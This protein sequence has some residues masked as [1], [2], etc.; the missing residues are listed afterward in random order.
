MS[1]AAQK[2]MDVD[3]FLAW[4]EGRTRPGELR[5]GKPVM[6]SPERALH[7]LAEYE[8]QKALET[9]IA[10]ARLPCRLLPDGMTVRITARN[11]FEPDALVVCPSP[12]DFSAM[13][14]PN[15][16][17]VVEVLSL[18]T[19]ADD[20]GIRL[21]GYFSLPCVEHYLIVDADRPVLAQ[22]RASERAI[23]TRPARF[24][25]VADALLEAK[26][27][28]WR[29]Q[30]HREQWRIALAE[31]AAALRARNRA[32]PQ[33]VP[34]CETR[35]PPCRARCRRLRPAVLRRRRPTRSPLR[36]SSDAPSAWA[37]DAASGT[38]FRNALDSCERLMRFR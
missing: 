12:S 20:H 16:V 4:A 31:T 17:I 11:A 1:D 14:I 22:T 25:Q 36:F 34:A 8:A 27:H 2:D 15:P 21:G 7:A 10:R 23:E 26:S 38:F 13:E 6:V 28:E 5:D 19:V 35:S 18:S 30:K 24:G 33:S 3:A 29:N 37:A 32:P 9:G